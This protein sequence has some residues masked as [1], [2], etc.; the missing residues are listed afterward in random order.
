MTTHTHIQSRVKLGKTTGII[1]GDLM[2][3]KMEWGGLRW[4]DK[5]FQV[6]TWEKT[7]EEHE[8]G[9]TSPEHRAHGGQWLTENG[10]TKSGHL[11]WPWETGQNLVGF[12][13]NV[14][15]WRLLEGRGEWTDHR[16]ICR[17][18]GSRG[19]VEPKRLTRSWWQQLWGSGSQFYRFLGPHTVPC[20][21]L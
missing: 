6:W 13:T 2:S 19:N 16:R 8:T 18:H 9:E 14:S 5:V 3:G 7:P 11:W 4:R 21:G 20:K 12:K 1:A 10:K 15:P 17:L